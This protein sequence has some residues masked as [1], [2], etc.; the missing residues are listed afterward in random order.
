MF[1]DPD[2]NRPNHVAL[3]EALKDIPSRNDTTTQRS[4]LLIVHSEFSSSFLKRKNW[5]K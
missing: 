1:R 3:F 5:M 4:I 2:W